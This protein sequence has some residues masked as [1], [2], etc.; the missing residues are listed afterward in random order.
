MRFAGKRVLITGAGGGIGRATAQ[1]LAAEGAELVLADIN[2]TGLADTATLLPEP[3]TTRQHDAGSI[4]SCETLIASLDGRLDA[5]LNIAGILKWGP[6]ADF[7]AEDFA[8]VMAVNATGTYALCRAA[9]PLLVASRGCIVNTASTAA[10]QGIAYTVAYAASKHAVAAI[11]KSLAIEYAAA[12]V[13]IN[14]V[15][16]GHVD[17]A[18]GRQAPPAGVADWALVM[19]NAPKLPD[20]TLPPADVAEAIAYLASPAAARMTGSLLVIDGGQLAG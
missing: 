6:T 4:T 12:G 10:L 19:R 9:L 15:C 1:L 2:T 11:T 18:M 14:A 13:R 8:A 20:G 7:S 5:L 16:P 17:T 3:V